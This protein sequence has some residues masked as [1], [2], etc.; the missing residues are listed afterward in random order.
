[1]KGLTPLNRT[2]SQEMDASWDEYTLCVAPQPLIDYA[3][4]ARW[5]RVAGKWQD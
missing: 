5:M 1:M 4:F 2:Q 3:C